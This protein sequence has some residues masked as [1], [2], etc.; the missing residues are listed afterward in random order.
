MPYIKKEQREELD[1]AI[2]MLSDTILKT[3]ESERAGRLNYIITRLLARSLDLTSP[4]YEN[5]NRA[6]GILECAKLEF[7]QRIAVS[8][9]RRKYEENGDVIE[10]DEWT[11][12]SQMRDVSN[13]IQPRPIS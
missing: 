7:Y 8:Y 3:N 9:E 6:V 1:E 13:P 5:I 4:K 2:K 12:K 10:Y 11:R